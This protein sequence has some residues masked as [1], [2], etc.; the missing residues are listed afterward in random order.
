[1][2]FPI[3]CSS[4]LALAY[5]QQGKL[6]E[7]GAVLAQYEGFL[8]AFAAASNRPLTISRNA[9]EYAGVAME[10]GRIQDARRIID[11]GV[12][13]LRTARSGEGSIW[14]ARLRNQAALIEM[15]EG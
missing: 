12:Q 5:R 2:F 15:F 8:R 1:S 14:L 11:E 7:A 3:S 13:G 10:Q 9:A 4:S 6:T